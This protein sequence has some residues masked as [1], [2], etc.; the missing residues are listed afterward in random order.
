MSETVDLNVTASHLFFLQS[1]VDL[2]Q[3]VPGAALRG[4]LSGTTN[5]YVNVVGLQVSYRA[6]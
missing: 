5:A 3:T 2:S 6:D 4:D 1:N